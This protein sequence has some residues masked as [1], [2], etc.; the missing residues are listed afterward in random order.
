LAW[1]HR[2]E[3]DAKWEYLRRSTD[4]DAAGDDWQ[5]QRGSSLPDVRA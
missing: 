1:Q 4:H 5:R 3:T 2:V